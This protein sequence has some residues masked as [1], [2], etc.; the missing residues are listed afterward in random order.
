MK[1]L[2]AMLLFTFATVSLAQRQ[3][4]M[5]TYDAVITRIIDGDTVAFRADF[6][7]AP[8]KKELSI[9]VY[10]VDTPEKGHRAKC[11]QE[12][13]RGLAATEFTKQAIAR[14]SRKQIALW[15]WDKYGGR[16]LGDV[17]LD[18]QSLR[19]M[20]IQRGLAREYYGEAK[21]SWC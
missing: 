18:G 20:L 17:L 7:P 13:E 4:Q 15:D 10:G 8:L 5:V 14:A 3:P 9:R 11:P 6:L 12:N 19:Q 16:V 1:T 21:T 2:L